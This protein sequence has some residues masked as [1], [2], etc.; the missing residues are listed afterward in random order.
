MSDLWKHQR[1][2]SSLEY[3]LR[4]NGNGGPT[5]CDSLTMLPTELIVEVMKRLGRVSLASF[6]NAK[7]TC[8]TLR[9][10][11]ERACVVKEAA[12][13]ELPMLCEVG[14]PSIERVLDSA[15]IAGN[16]QALF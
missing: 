14:N 9:D 10:V 1:E 13:R 6:I 5:H 2:S 4:G 7:A 3:V 11:G 8:K 15:L 16:Y 12:I